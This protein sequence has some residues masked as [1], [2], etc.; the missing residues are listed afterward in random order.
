[1]LDSRAG[2]WDSVRQT[3]A[4]QFEQDKTNFIYRRSRKGV[5]IRVSAEEYKKFIDKFGRDLRRTKW[6]MYICLILVFSVAI[7]FSLLRV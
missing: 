6:L 3:L 4:D 5:A 2:T 7:E 1:M